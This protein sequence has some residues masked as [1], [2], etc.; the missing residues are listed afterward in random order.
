LKH[1][2]VDESLRSH[3]E[4]EDSEFAAV[5]SGIQAFDYSGR[6]WLQSAYEHGKPKPGN[7][8]HIGK[9][10]LTTEVAPWIMKALSTHKPSPEVLVL[11]K[12][13]AQQYHD[14][15]E[16]ERATTTGLHDI[17]SIELTYQCT[18]E[19][20]AAILLA[21]DETDEPGKWVTVSGRLR[22]KTQ[23]HST[24]VRQWNQIIDCMRRKRVVMTISP[25]G[26]ASIQTWNAIHLSSR[27]FPS[28]C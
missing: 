9:F 17:D 26:V 12:P 3:D 7:M 2:G 19:I 16:Q 1:S 8:R 10:A 5:R 23:N 22:F 27:N 24:H 6:V 13:Y 14:S 28:T 4:C 11:I 25:P 18:L 20:C 21:A 15:I